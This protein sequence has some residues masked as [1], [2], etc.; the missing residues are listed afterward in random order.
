M[1]NIF[2]IEKHSSM[3]KKFFWCENCAS[4][5]RCG[6]INERS[7]FNIQTRATFTEEPF[8]LNDP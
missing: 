3:K 1:I 4:T 6:Y 2:N 8:A 5:Q 7:S